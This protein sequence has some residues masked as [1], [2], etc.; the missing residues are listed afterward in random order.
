[1]ISVKK[2]TI[3]G[4]MAVVAFTGAATATVNAVDSTHIISGNTS[5]AENSPGWMF[6]RDLSTQ[7]PYEFNTDASS[8]GTGSLYVFPITN[9]G[10]SNNDKFIGE[11][12]MN[13]QLSDI[14]GI[15]YDFKIGATGEV[16]DKDHFYMSV[17]VNFG[18]SDDFKFYDCRYNVVPTTGSTESFTTVTFDPSQA[19]S[20]TTRGGA[21]ASPFTCPAIPNGMNNLSAGSNIRAIALN[22]GDTSA[23]DLGVEGYLDNVVITEG[24]DKTIFDFEPEIEA[25]PTPTATPTVT[26]TMDPFAIPTECSNISGLGAPIIGTNKS[27]KI[28]GTSGNDLIF[29]LGGSDKIDGK[30]GHDCIVGGQGSDKIVGGNGD[31]VILGNEDSD[32]LDGND[33]S[34][35][36]Y[37]NGGSD[38]LKGGNNNDTLWGGNDSDSL[39]GEGGSDTLYGEGGSDS[40]DGGNDNDTLDGGDGSDSAKGGSGNNDACTAE[41]VKQCEA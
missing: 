31:D 14:D 19:Y 33:G 11:Y 1:M 7:S 10:N 28:N 18:Q 4:L 39:K 21:N 5:I 2:I 6:N 29:G 37:G 36:L 15:S 38:S 40:L 34:D 35:T 3:A 22:V 12:F 13:K 16:A 24:D 27:E 9:S 23:N 26:P 41:T 17:Y 30:G 20:V 8:I 32:S 25:T